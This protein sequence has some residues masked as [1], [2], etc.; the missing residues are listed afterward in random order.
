MTGQN[1]ADLA[2]V[3][4]RLQ[5]LMGRKPAMRK[6]GRRRQV[7]R[8]SF[9]TSAQ[10]VEEAG[11]Q[12]AQRVIERLSE[13]YQVVAH[14]VGQVVCMGRAMDNVGENSCATPTLRCT[15]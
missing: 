7:R 8:S 6:A 3:S 4:A 1:Q 11:S 2:Q 9:A 13:P 15:G 5:S 10:T 12:L 14:V